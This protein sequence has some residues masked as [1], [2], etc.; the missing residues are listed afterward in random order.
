MSRTSRLRRRR[1]GPTW[2]R[3]PLVLDDSLDRV[4]QATPVQGRT[5][6]NPSHPLKPKRLTTTEL[7]AS[8]DPHP[9]SQLKTLSLILVRVPWTGVVSP[10]RL[11][12]GEFPRGV[13]ATRTKFHAKLL[14]ALWNFRHF[15][16]ESFTPAV[17]TKVHETT[18]HKHF[19]VNLGGR[20]RWEVQVGG[21]GGTRP[22]YGPQGTRRRASCRPTRVN[23]GDSK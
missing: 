8:T 18:R 20:F 12:Q 23:L 5:P 2:T 16:W 15:P 11:H 7:G 21:P 3:T 13:S 22:P 9:K 14:P 17:P 1:R 10:N 6:T 19:W 4:S